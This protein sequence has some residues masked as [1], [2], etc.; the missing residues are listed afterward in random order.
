MSRGVLSP[1]YETSQLTPEHVMQLAIGTEEMETRTETTR[2][3]DS[4]DSIGW[5]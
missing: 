3:D 5:P 4:D 1:A 2:A